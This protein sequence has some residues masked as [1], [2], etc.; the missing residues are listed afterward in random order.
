MSADPLLTLEHALERCAGVVMEAATAGVVAAGL[1]RFD[2]GF[3]RGVDIN[4][5]RY[6]LPK[7]AY[8]YG[9]PMIRTGELRESYLARVQRAGGSTQIVFY[10]VR[11]YAEYLRSGTYKMDP[12]QH[13][14]KPGEAPPPDLHAAF[15]RVG[16]TAM[17]RYWAEV[18]L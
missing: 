18:R 4:G 1:Q 2:K 10:N 8:K 16:E 6:Q 7:D 9:P 17:A 15:E 11:P 14:P 3:V 12:R 5:K 13:M